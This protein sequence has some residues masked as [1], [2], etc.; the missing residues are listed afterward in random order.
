[1]AADPTTLVTGATGFIGSV[2]TRRLVADGADVRILRRESSSLDLLGS[3][4]EHVDH[5]VGDVTRAQSLVRAME[6]IERVYHVAGKVSFAR[7]DRA[8]LRRVNAE[9]TANVVNA[10]LEAGVERLVHTSS[11]AALGRP[12]GEDA[13]IDETTEWV[14]APERS[15]Y[16]QTKHRAELEVHRGIA[17]GLD[18]VIVN[19]SVVFGVGRRGTNTRRIVEAVRR[20]WLPGVPPGGTNVVDVQDVVAG[21]RKAMRRGETGRRYLLGGENLAWR[22]II[23]TLSEAFGVAPPRYTIPSSVLRAGATAAEAGAFLTRTRPLLPRATAR[24]ATR[25][26]RYDNTRAREELGCTFRPFRATA[27]RIAEALA[28]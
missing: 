14:S 23:E 16:A 11:I 24:T 17:E 19:P 10:A 5:A 25:T 18:A 15:V 4:A 7:R 2:L 21:H 8:M 22:T 27:L 12:V 13:L 6:G 3:V 20:G 26:L 9:G 1:M 28:V